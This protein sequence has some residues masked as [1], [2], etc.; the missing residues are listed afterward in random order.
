[1]GST[2]AT[3]MASDG[4]THA[5]LL[6]TSSPKPAN[7]GWRPAVRTVLALVA[8]LPLLG[9]AVLT[10]ISASSSWSNRQY[11]QQAAKDVMV[12][13]QI[14]Q[15][16]LEMNQAAIPMVLVASANSIGISEKI[17]SLLVGIN[18]MKGPISLPYAQHLLQSNPIL[19]ATPALKADDQANLQLDSQ[20]EAGNGSYASATKI[21]DHF[22]NAID[23]YWVSKYEQ[24]G[25]YVSK[26]NPPGS[27]ETHLATLRQTY[28]SFDAGIYSDRSAI[29]VLEGI[30]GEAPKLMLMQEVFEFQQAASQFQNSLGPKALKAW[31]TLNSDPHVRS[32]QH[33]INQALSLA[34]NGGKAPYLTNEKQ[35][36]IAVRLVIFDVADLSNLVQS[37]ANDLVT[38]AN[39][40]ANVAKKDFLLEIIFLLALLGFSVGGVLIVGGSLTKP[41]KALSGAALRIHSG[42][43][44]LEE[45]EDRG[46][47]EVA[48]T[49]EAFN[50]M[51]TTLKAVER[52]TVALA[53]EDLEH[54]DL[55]NPLPGK[56]GQALQAA[57]DQLA[58]RIKE[59]EEQR[60]Q[61]Y[62]AAT[63]DRLTNLLNRAAVFDYLTTNVAQRRLS[64]ES[65]AVLFVD[66][67]G[68]KPLNDT[69]G[70]EA[71]DAAIQATGEALV[72]ATNPCDVVGR[73]GGDEF[74]SVL[75]HEHSQD[76]DA[77]A[78]KMREQVSKKTIVAN[79]KEVSLQA[80]VGVALTECD[81]KTD[82]MELVKLADQ[83]M[84]EAKRAARQAKT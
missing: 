10:G 16:R 57:V 30:G 75:C 67:D 53:E 8:L 61:L 60:Q 13:K 82:P 83:R 39:H 6:E 65:V 36:G 78:L 81:A 64:G 50:V 22:A 24:L 77:V 9:I 34:E 31:K 43:F 84:Y 14:A 11:A 28:A 58:T 3:D 4:K 66:I 46:P 71:G 44:D 33:I 12:L 47:R 19:Q 70:H 29:D 35:A 45:L 2:P 48:T 79:G 63:H 27:F 72:E 37:A 76:G 20:I 49:M 25:S 21:L 54:A 68:L 7:R 73:L 80:S 26:W 38:Q 59:R 40:Q 69:Y 41:L 42:D 52:K 51:S 55:S 15:A 23:N 1:M 17:V 56:T 18:L 5:N 32:T 62:E 74:L